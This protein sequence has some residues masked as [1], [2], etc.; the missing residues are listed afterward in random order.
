MCK[1]VSDGDSGSIIRVTQLI[2]LS[3]VWVRETNYTEKCDFL[4]IFKFLP[5]FS[6]LSPCLVSETDTEHYGW[7]VELCVCEGEQLDRTAGTIS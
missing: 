3:L 5:S 6:L 1:A 4:A 2:R 7:A